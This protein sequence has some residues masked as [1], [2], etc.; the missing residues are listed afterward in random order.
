MGTRVKVTYLALDE[1]KMPIVSAD[2]FDNLKRGVDDYFGIGQDPKARY[3]G[4]TPY[5]SKYPDP[6]EGYWEYEV[7][8][9]DQPEREKVHI[10][11]IDFYPHTVYETE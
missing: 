9:R 2:T 11:C 4:Y 1:E 6:Y 8:Y 5:S 10:L 3:L 7:T